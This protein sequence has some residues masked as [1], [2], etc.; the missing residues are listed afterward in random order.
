MTRS[1]HHLAVLAAV[2]CLCSGQA[3]AQMLEDPVMQ[4]LYA[5]ERHGELQR[6]AGQ[7]L[8]AQADNAQAVL[9]LA[10]AALAREDAAARQEVLRRAQDCTVRQPRA[11]PCHYALGVVLGVQAM[12]EGMFKAARSA[13]TVQKALVSAHGLEPAWYPARS[14]LVEFYILAPGF[15]GGDPTRA[16]ELARG[17]PTPEQTRALQA[18]IAMSERRFDVALQGLSALP[19]GLPSDV[20]ED[21]RSW[22]VLSSLGLINAGQADQA[23]AALERLQREYPRHAG[24]AYA[25]GRVRAEQ[26]AHDQALKLYGLAAG[27]LG[28]DNWPIAYRL[29]IAYQQLGR[30]DA[31]Q[32]ELQRFVAARKGQKA[33]LE[34]ARKR[35]DQLRS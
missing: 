18:R 16:A 5:A 30:N 26:S 10:L 31:A 35:L 8:A 20:A 13:G 17:A 19:G 22:T 11:A 23:Q 6:V 3:G 9:G 21:V 12:S 14:A 7:H 27:L 28:A 33:A 2:S 4:A 25:L 15:M 24:P 29:G 32:A 34:D 1:R